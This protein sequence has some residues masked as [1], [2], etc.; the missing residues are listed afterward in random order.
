MANVT[1]EAVRRRDDSVE[2]EGL[3]KVWRVQVRDKARDEWVQQQ[4]LFVE[5]IRKEIL[6]LGE[7]YVQVWEK[8]REPKKKA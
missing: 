6:F 7:S 2:G 4:D 8:R 3:G 1:H 5:D